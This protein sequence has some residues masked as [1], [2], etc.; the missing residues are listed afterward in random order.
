MN[1]DR[2]RRLL[3]ADAAGHHLAPDSL[4]RIRQRVASVRRERSQRRVATGLVAAALVAAGVVVPLK[5]VGGVTPE[6]RV[7]TP[8]I[9]SPAGPTPTIRPLAGTTTTT[10]PLSPPTSANF[11][12]VAV[13]GDVDGD[14]RPDTA[15][16]VYRGPAPTTGTPYTGE[17]DLVVDMT[18]LGRQTVAF[19]ALPP[20]F[21]NARIVAS[22]DANDDGHAELFVEIGSGASTQTWTIFTLMGGRVRQVT[23]GGQPIQLLVGGS[24]THQDGFICQGSQFVER[25]ATASQTG[26]ATQTSTYT[27]DGA[28][29]AHQSSVNGQST[30]EGSSDYGSVRCGDFYQ[31]P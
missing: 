8:G 2:L 6:Q 5:I 30:L 21:F 24:V 22:V 18:S 4:G 25:S 28:Q 7:A 10:P 20:S 29:L 13:D 3:E 23:V 11:G 12:R 19:Q 9:D 27:W 14:G 15:R 26:Y 16:V 17:Y 1:E 31:A